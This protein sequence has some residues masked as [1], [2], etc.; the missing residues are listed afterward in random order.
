MMSGNEARYSLGL[1]AVPKGGCNFKA[2]DE[3]VDE[4]HPLLFKPFDFADFLD[5]R[6]SEKGLMDQFSLHTYCG[7]DSVP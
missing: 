5:Y 1:F 3:L 7:V 6:F 4:E 2:P